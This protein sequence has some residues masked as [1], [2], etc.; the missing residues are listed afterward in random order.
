MW[1]P[2]ASGLLPLNVSFHIIILFAWQCSVWQWERLISKLLC[3]LCWMAQALTQLLREKLKDLLFFIPLQ[4]NGRSWDLLAA[5]T[6]R[7]SIAKS[8]RNKVMV[9]KFQ[10]QNTAEM[11]LIHWD[12]YFLGH[13]LVCWLVRPPT[14][15][16][17]FYLSA[18]FGLASVALLLCIK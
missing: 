18:C 16:I 10:W 9:T 13:Y 14:L 7:Q 8:R 1:W 6:W 15:A 2:R 3:W 11:W 17:W 5:L 4:L 12:D